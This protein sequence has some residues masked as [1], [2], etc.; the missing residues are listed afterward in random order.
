MALPVI[1][2]PRDKVQSIEDC[3]TAT[4]ATTQATSEGI[5]RAEPQGRRG[6]KGRSLSTFVACGACLP[7]CMCSLSPTLSRRGNT[8]NHTKVGRGRDRYLITR[9]RS[10]PTNPCP[11]ESYSYG[12]TN[13]MNQTLQTVGLT[14]SVR[15]ATIHLSNSDIEY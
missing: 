14:G 2:E 8:Q 3:A 10:N 1:K 13:S 9:H 4:S 12:A 6:G 15:H 7:R 11:V 5:C